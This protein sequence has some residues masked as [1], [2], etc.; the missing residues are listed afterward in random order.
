MQLK[1]VELRL[2][3]QAQPAY[4]APVTFDVLLLQVL[5]EPAALAN[6]LQET[7]PRME[8]VFV[9]AHVLGHVPDTA[10]EQRNLYLRRTRVAVVG[11]ILPDYFVLIL[12]YRQLLCSS[13]FSYCLNLFL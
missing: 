6:H 1:L 4:E 8:I 9:L 5:Q 11:R 12:Y 2:A 13:L 7:P 10:G 3:A